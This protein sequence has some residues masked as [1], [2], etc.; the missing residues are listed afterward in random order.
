MQIDSVAMPARRIAN[1]DPNPLPVVAEPLP[2]RDVPKS[3][4][5]TQTPAAIQS[6][7]A[8]VTQTLRVAGRDLAFSVDEASGKT[9]VRI[10]HAD[11]GELIRQIPEEELLALAAFLRSGGAPDSL[12]VEQ[13]A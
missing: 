2:E 4:A 5:Q 11:S 13:W 1:T 6:V 8:E 9:V 7:A 3:D 10:T 12:G